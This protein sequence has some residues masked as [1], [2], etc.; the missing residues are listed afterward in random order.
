MLKNHL[1]AEVPG[2]SVVRRLAQAAVVAIALVA[3]VRVTPAIAA[4][5]TESYLRAPDGSGQVRALVI[6]ID[7]YRYVR[8]LK[9]ATA[10][11]RDI[12]D[13]LLR[14]GVADLT[15]LIDD[16]AARAAVMRDIQGRADRS[17]PGDLVILSIAGH[18]AQEPE[19]VK[20][21]EPDGKDDVFL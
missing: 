15:T 18:G 4:A 6:G 8:P 16:Q 20:G 1:A 2:K 9:G 21:S 19:H 13:V 14:M 10:D 7:A 5:S 3:P 12:A 11:A 17:G